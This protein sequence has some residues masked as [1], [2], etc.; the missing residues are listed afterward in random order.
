MAVK[1]KRKDLL[2]EIDE[3]RR[4][5]SVLRGLLELQTAPKPFVVEPAPTQPPY[6]RDRYMRWN[7]VTCL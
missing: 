3:L 6:D 5:V 7:E 4:Q 1:P 2:R